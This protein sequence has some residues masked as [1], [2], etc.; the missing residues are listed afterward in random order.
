MTKPRRDAE[1]QCRHKRTKAVSWNQL[2]S[3]RVP[4]GGNGRRWFEHAFGPS[5][6]RSDPIL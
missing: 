5:G 6:C 3:H 1:N 4:G 2:L